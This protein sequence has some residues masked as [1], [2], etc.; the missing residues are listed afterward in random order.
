VSLSPGL[1]ANCALPDFRNTR[2]RLLWVDSGRSQSARIKIQTDGSYS[3]GVDFCRFFF[4]RKRIR[5]R[6]FG[7]T[8]FTSRV[9]E[10]AHDPR[11]QRSDRG[12]EPRARRAFARMGRA[13]RASGRDPIGDVA[14]RRGRTPVARMM[15]SAARTRRKFSALQSLEKSQNAERI[16]ILRE[17]VPRAGERPRTPRRKARHAGGAAREPEKTAE[18]I[19]D[20]LNRDVSVGSR[21][22]R[23]TAKRSR[24]EMAP[25]RFEKIESGPGN[26]DV[27]HGCA[28][29]RARLRLT[30]HGNDEVAMLQKKSA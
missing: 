7:S 28:A 14:S 2:D 24:P 16:S 11:R 22:E 21:R 6:V 12:D 18:P 3:G 13:E 5:V 15:G 20:L 19:V 9:A 17:P 30:S 1:F 8:R 4:L 23:L 10:P 29:D 25:Q 27:V 26:G